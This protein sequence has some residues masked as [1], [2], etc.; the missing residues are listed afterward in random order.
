M[1]VEDNVIVVC[2][3]MMMVITIV[4]IVMMMMM[5]NAKDK[6]V[7]APVAEAMQSDTVPGL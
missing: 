1:N 7:S 6:S 3:K 2:K 4:M 5:M